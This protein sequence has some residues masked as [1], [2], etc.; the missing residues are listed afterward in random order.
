MKLIVIGASGLIGN[1]VCQMAHERCIDVIGTA[2]NSHN[3]KYIPYEIGKDTPEK[4]LDNLRDYT[5]TTENMFAVIAGAITNMQRCYEDEF[6]SYGVNV[7]GICE[8]AEVLY[9][10]KIKSIFLSTDAVFDGLNGN[11][12]E[13]DKPNP[14]CA[15]GRQKASAEARLRDTIPDILI[16]R[17]GKQVDTCLENNS[18]LADI[19]RQKKTYGTVRC[20]KGLIFNPTYLEDTASCIIAGLQE[21]MEG[22]FHV[23]NPEIFSRYDIAN[24][25]FKKLKEDDA[26]VME[27]AVETFGFKEPRPLN[28]SMLTGKF[29]GVFPHSF[30]SMEQVIEKITSDLMR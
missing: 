29:Q 26:I 15:Y 20:I 13:S 28:T 9:S 1:A 11:Y 5:A 3:G 21:G 27:D 14:V 17:L 2:T 25:F 10:Q 12:T 6:T 22:I 19:Y 23:A 18:L 7:T 16:Y 4:L 24:M 8:L 30:L